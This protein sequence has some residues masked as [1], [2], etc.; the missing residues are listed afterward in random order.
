MNIGLSTKRLKAIMIEPAVDDV[1]TKFIVLLTKMYVHSKLMI[2]TG[3]LHGNLY[4]LCEM[5]IYV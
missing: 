4:K 2:I 3:L 5:H 1:L